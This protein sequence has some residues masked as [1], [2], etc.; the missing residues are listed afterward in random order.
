MVG[1]G[2][3]V[4]A[5]STITRTI[6][7]QNCTIGENV[8]VLLCLHFDETCFLCVIFASVIVFSCCVCVCVCVC[9][10]QTRLASQMVSFYCILF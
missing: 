8:Q 2:T 7:G 10:E 6:I 1:G 3:V 9:I 5:N 4:G